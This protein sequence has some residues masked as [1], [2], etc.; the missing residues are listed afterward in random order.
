MKKICVTT[1][2]ATI[3]TAFV[4]CTNKLG[5]PASSAVV[6][7]QTE[8]VVFNVNTDKN[9]SLTKSIIAESLVIKIPSVFF[10]DTTGNY[11]P[12]VKQNIQKKLDC[13]RWLRQHWWKKSL[14]REFQRLQLPFY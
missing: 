1:A 5:S 8:K 14:S 3:S 7:E 13:L 12:G 11:V 10:F 2:I 4:S 6:E 9:V